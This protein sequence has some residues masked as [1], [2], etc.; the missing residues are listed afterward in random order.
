MPPSTVPSRLI[1]PA[2]KS[3]ASTSDVFP[4]PRCPVTAT[5]RIFPG[6]VG[7]AGDSSSGRGER[8][9]ILPP[10][11]I[12][13][14]PLDVVAGRGRLP[15]LPA[16]VPGL[17]RRRG[18]RPARDHPAA[19]PPRLP[20]RGRALALADLPLAARGLRLRRLRTTPAIDPQFG[21]LD[22]FDELVAAAHERGLRVLLD[23]VPCHTSIEH[24]WF[25]E[26]P[27]R[28]IWSP[29]DGP[30]NNWVSAFGGPAWSRDEQSGRWYLHSFYPEQPDLELA[31]P[32]GRRRDA[33]RR[34]LLARPRRG[35]V[36]PGRDRPARQGRAAA[37]RPARE[38]SRSPCRCTR[39]PR[40]LEM[41][42]S[43]NR[44]EAIEALRPLR[45]AAGDAL[46]VGESSIRPVER[47]RAVAR[48]ARPRLRLRVSLLALGRR[49]PARRDRAGRRARARGLGDVEPRLRPARDP[50]R[51]RE[52]PGRRGAAAHASRR[53]R[54]STRGTSSG[55]RTGPVPR[56]PTTAPAATGC[57][58]RCSGTRP[59][60][61]S[62][63]ASHGCRSSIPRPQRRR[64]SGP[65]PAR[66]STSTG[67]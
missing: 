52:P 13:P 19:R 20:R 49:A 63:R 45:E 38:R 47:V 1:A 28:Y 15:D 39:T 2:W 24:P 12:Y 7:I 9:P 46:L 53:R 42:Y 62:P 29:V 3:I 34:P 21:T 4:V 43:G 30:P 32:G 58:T 40:R 6:S 35:R 56:R 31:Q 59:P 33:G 48:G 55:W 37:R 23:L 60:A 26:H 44:P 8:V 17:G 64:T 41:R 10:G 16:L 11:G 18:R 22:D 36:P 51:P 14:R 25:R 27:D 67:A 66:C 5:L 54:S 57:A 50:R 61:V 65:T